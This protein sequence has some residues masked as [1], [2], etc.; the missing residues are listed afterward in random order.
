[1]VW[2]KV[3]TQRN[4]F[5]HQNSDNLREFRLSCSVSPLHCES[6][7]DSGVYDAEINLTAQRVNNAALDG[8][9]AAA[10]DFH[11][12]LG[13]PG[14]GAL[15]GQDGVVGFGGRQGQNWVKFRLFD[16][17]YLRTTN[18]I[19]Q[20]FGAPTYDRANLSQ[21]SEALTLGPNDDAIVIE[22]TVTWDDLYP[23]IPQGD[24]FMRWRF[25]P[26][27]L[28]EEFVI[29]QAAREWIAANRAPQF[30]A[31]QWFGMIF[32]FD[33][34]DIPKRLVDGVLKQ[35]SDDTTSTGVTELRDSLDRLLALLPIDYVYAGAQPKVPVLGTHYAALSK[36]WF[37]GTVNG[38]TGNFLFVGVPVTTLAGLQTG[39]LV[40]DPTINLQVSATGDDGNQN[41]ASTWD[42]TTVWQGK[43]STVP[44]YGTSRILNVTVPQGATINSATYTITETGSIDGTITNCHMKLAAQAIDTALQPSGSN[45]PSG[46]SWGAQSTSFDPATWVNNHTD[47]LSAT[48]IVQEVVNRAGWVSGNAMNF[49]L[50]D[51][52]TSDDSTDGETYDYGASAAK[53]AKLDVTYTASGAAT[54]IP[55][56]MKQYRQ[57]WS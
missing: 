2:N 56:F 22:N 18:R 23:A 34:S 4:G 3:A 48:A 41:G 54:P 55:V 15:A 44:E 39:D 36:R 24:I 12:A 16:T 5:T 8:W 29:T 51:R 9:T 19:L 6:V 40:F 33:L 53:S 27:G 37:Q 46:W 38:V 1:M 45:L 49:A 13:S 52:G 28:K 47:A 25:R 35:S 31:T 30:P 11:Y 26:D 42:A 20:L 43:W 17:G 10:A 14:A 32:Q 7:L 21:S 57:R 50:F